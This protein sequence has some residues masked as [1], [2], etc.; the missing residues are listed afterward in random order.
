MKFVIY[1]FFSKCDQ[2]RSFL[3][4]WWHLQK[5]SLIENLILFKTLFAIF[6]SQNWSSK[7]FKL[8]LLPFCFRRVCYWEISFWCVNI[9]YWYCRPFT[10]RLIVSETL[11]RAI[12]RKNKTLETQSL[13]R[14]SICTTDTMD[15]T[16]VTPTP[17]YFT[18]YS[19]KSMIASKVRFWY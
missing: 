2:N 17:L 7:M 16:F 5:K 11:F 12:L 1:D 18:W 19:T 10:S 9:F 6:G 15:I 8:M 13:S 4:I 14:V 3:Q